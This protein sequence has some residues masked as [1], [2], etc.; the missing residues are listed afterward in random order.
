MAA[1]VA[2]YTPAAPLPG[3]KIRRS[4]GDPLTLELRPTPDLLAASSKVARPDQLMVGFALEPADGLK[5]SATDKLRRKGVDLL[6][7]NPLETME[8]PDIEATLIASE[9]LKSF[10][11]QTPRLTK[12]QFAQWLLPIL[13]DA[14]LAKRS[15]NSSK[16]THA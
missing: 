3:A 14:W 15:R 5:A 9:P 1:A 7:A 10:E 13:N 12:T 8:S 2:D 4:E 16:S 6:V 11:Q